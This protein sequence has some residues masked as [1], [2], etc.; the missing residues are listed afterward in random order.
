MA[1][2]KERLKVAMDAATKSVERSKLDV[3]KLLRNVCDFDLMPRMVWDFDGNI[4]YVNESFSRLLGYE[5]SEMIGKPFQPFIHPDSLEASLNVY[6]EN[7]GNGRSLMVDFDNSYIHKDGSE[8]KLRWLRGW[9]DEDLKMGSGQVKL[10]N[11]VNK[12]IIY[13]DDEESACKAFKA[14]YRRDFNVITTTDASEVFELIEVHSPLCVVADQRMPGELKG[15]DVLAR[16]AE[17]Y[18]DIR[19]I[20]TTAYMDY[21]AAE[22]AINK[23]HVQN[24]VRKPWNLSEL[25]DILAA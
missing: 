6:F 14:N 13:V 4:L 25:H 15:V 5:Q 18:P 11:A 12:T 19:R 16:V 22:N 7:I 23:A 1:D 21:E 3:S 8:V 10:R 17:T 24:L 2:L 20:L 9:N